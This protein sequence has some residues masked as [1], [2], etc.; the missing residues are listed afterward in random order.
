MN[1]DLT[2][3]IPASQKQVVTGTAIISF[4]LA[5]R[6]DVVLDFQGTFSGACIINGKQRTVTY[7]KEHIVLPMK[8]MKEGLNTVA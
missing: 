2:F 8:Q 5:E 4:M 6:D 7:Q 1:Y 3:N